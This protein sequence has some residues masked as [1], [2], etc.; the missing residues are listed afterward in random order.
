MHAGDEYTAGDETSLADA[1]QLARCIHKPSCCL[2]SRNIE[3][4]L[5]SFYL[6][7][8]LEVR[9]P[10]ARTQSDRRRLGSV[11]GL[12]PRVRVR[13]GYEFVSCRRHGDQRLIGPVT[14]PIATSY[15]YRVRI[16][17]S[18]N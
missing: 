5:S 16:H 13:A 3:F 1:S 2:T 15:Y 18:H 6:S 9:L 17:L 4:S 10:D 11:T 7:K 14:G 12:G 8:C